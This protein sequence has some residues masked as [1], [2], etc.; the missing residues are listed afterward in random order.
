MTKQMTY[1]EK[2]QSPE[3]QKRR[4]EIFTRDGFACRNCGD[5]TRP[6][7]VHHRLYLRGAAPWQYVDGAL[8]TLCEDCHARWHELQDRIAALLCGLSPTQFLDIRTDITLSQ[9]GEYLRAAGHAKELEDR[10]A[11]A[12]AEGYAKA[13]EVWRKGLSKLDRES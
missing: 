7:H 11:A 5:K 1:A 6:L 12:Y 2:L 13:E 9:L 8:V 3:W 10:W 4:L